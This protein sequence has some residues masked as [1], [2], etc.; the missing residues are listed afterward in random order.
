LPQPT[1]P[2]PRQS[3]ERRAA[4]PSALGIGVSGSRVPGLAL[5]GDARR[6]DHLDPLHRADVARAEG[7]HRLAQRADEVLRAVGD[8]AGPSRI[9]S[10]EPAVPDADAR[11]A[12]QRRRGSGHAPVGAPTGRLLRARQRRAEHQQVGAG[13]IALASSPP[14]RMPPSATTGT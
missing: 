4:T 12:R 1:T 2:L 6:V 10:S 3:D 7:G 11:A 9:F 13:A 5:A 8:D 14:R